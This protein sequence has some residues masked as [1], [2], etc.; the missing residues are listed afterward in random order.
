[1]LKNIAQIVLVASGSVASVAFAGPNLIVNGSFEDNSAEGTIYN[2]DNAEYTSTM[3]NSTAFSTGLQQIDIMQGDG[4]FGPTAIDGEYKVG[5]AS[6]YGQDALSLDLSSP[7]IDGKVYELSFYAIRVEGEFTEG[8]SGLEVG[9]SNAPDAFGT[10]IYSTGV[11]ATSGWQLFQTSFIA[12][13]TESYLT[14]RINQDV[15][16][17]TTW[18][19]IDA[20]S[21]NAVPSPG[22]LAI[23]SCAALLGSRRRS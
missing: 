6:G 17:I 11:V 23:M 4:E 7:L 20:F 12:T 2:L 16:E 15:A 3:S 21:L 1:M 19:H 22:S 8:D 10:N 5:L 9:V 18:L 14:L 13:G